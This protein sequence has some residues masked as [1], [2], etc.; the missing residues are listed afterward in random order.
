MV[1]K[2][3]GIRSKRYKLIHFYDD[4]DAWEFYDLD[5]D[6][7]EMKNAISDSRYA[8]TISAMH[9]KPDSMQKVY[10]VTSKEFE[11]VPEQRVEKAYDDF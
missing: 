5:E 11:R 6:P 3:Y 9:Q 4:N 2:H 1:K 10:G 8:Q 7:E